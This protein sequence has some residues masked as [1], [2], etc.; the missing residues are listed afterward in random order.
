M[1]PA[2]NPKDFPRDL[3]AQLRKVQREE[4]D[5]KIRIESLNRTCSQSHANVEAA[6]LLLSDTC[7]D[8]NELI[9]RV[10]EAKLSLQQLQ[11]E[12]LDLQDHIKEMRSDAFDAENQLKR[13]ES[14]ISALRCCERKKVLDADHLNTKLKNLSDKTEKGERKLLD[15]EDHIV[16]ATRETE[17]QEIAL[18]HMDAKY[19]LMRAT[20]QSV[21][22][23]AQ[24]RED[25]LPRKQRDR[26]GMQGS[27]IVP[28][29]NGTQS[30]SRGPEPLQ[31]VPTPTP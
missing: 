27:G 20:V 2:S 23:Q 19:D 6:D 15:A 12:K 25:A 14:S 7:D 21:L 4:K 10:I 8:E 13:I 26:P 18:R 11:D 17:R 16:T 22:M 1:Q 28:Q 3:Y 9:V 29:G 31:V 30:P 24:A 5:V